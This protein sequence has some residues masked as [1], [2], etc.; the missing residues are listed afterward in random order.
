VRLPVP[1][2]IA[3]ADLNIEIGFDLVDEA[4]GLPGE[5]PSGTS[6]ARRW[7]PM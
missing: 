1:V 2:W 3:L 4:D 5:L 7:A 6:S